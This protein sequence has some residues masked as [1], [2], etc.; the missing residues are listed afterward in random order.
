M[1]D[2]DDRLRSGITALA[3]RVEPES[4]PDQ[5]LGRITAARASWTS[6][7]RRAVFL[8]AAAVL[9]VVALAAAVLF[10]RRAGRGSV[11]VGPAGSSTTTTSAVPAGLFP[12]GLRAWGT[13]PFGGDVGANPIWDGREVLVVSVDP[14]TV[15]PAVHA[16]AFDPTTRAWRR[17]ADLPFVPPLPGDRGVDGTACDGQVVVWALDGET[18]VLASDRSSWRS[19][20]PA[21]AGLNTALEAPVYCDRSDVLFPGSGRRLSLTQR[22]WESIALVPGVGI[23]GLSAAW[24]GQEVVAKVIASA[25]NAVA[26]YDPASNSWMTIASPPFDVIGPFHL[27]WTGR[28]LV[29]I[30]DLGHSAGYDPS[31]DRWTRLPSVPPDVGYPAGLL[32]GALVESL[33]GRV[34]VASVHGVAVLDAHDRWH[35]EHTSI[36]STAHTVAGRALILWQPQVGLESYVPS[37]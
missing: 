35:V 26:A 20:P 7:G 16:A 28:R 31:T 36:V 27:A 30:D 12:A 1:T 24:T 8:A 33:G 23:N 3:E 34:T 6:S 4:T 18:A 5:V 10:A 14:S 32:G 2:L 13:G 21:P 25:P 37:A 15:R 9:V 29:G 19:L 11:D 22:R 17:L